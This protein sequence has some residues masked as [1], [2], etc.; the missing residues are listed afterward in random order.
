MNPKS[1][2]TLT[3]LVFILVISSAFL[4]M[5]EEEQQMKDEAMAEQQM[6]DEAM[7]E[8]QKQLEAWRNICRTQKRRFAFDIV[9]PSVKHLVAPE[10]RI[11]F[12]TRTGGCKKAMVICSEAAERNTGVIVK[13]HERLMRHLDKMKSVIQYGYLPFESIKTLIHD[14]AIVKFENK[15]TRLNRNNVVEQ[16]FGRYNINCIEDVVN[17]IANVGPHF[18]HVLSA[19]RPISIPV[20][21]KKPSKGKEKTHHGGGA[22]IGEDHII[23]LVGKMKIT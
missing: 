23:Q 7:A 2:I 4:P 6:K 19:I 21:G 22:V 3:S 10:S 8:Q 15:I 18:K 14:L 11:L 12:I 16:A 5:A 13:E 9:M 17:E 1:L 20:I